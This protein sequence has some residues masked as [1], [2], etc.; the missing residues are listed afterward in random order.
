MS[1]KG[2]NF[3]QINNASF[4]EDAMSI[5]QW[6][7]FQIP[8][9]PKLYW[10]YIPLPTAIMYHVHSWLSSTLYIRQNSYKCITNKYCVAWNASGVYACLCVHLSEPCRVATSSCLHG[11]SAAGQPLVQHGYQAFLFI[12]M[13]SLDYLQ[14]RVTELK[15]NA[16]L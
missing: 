4:T 16:N 7:C 13:V 14:L 5:R 11:G 1:R 10:L 9:W 3:C 2:I 6:T 8:A 15:H 12:G